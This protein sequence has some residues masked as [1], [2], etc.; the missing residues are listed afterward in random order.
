MFSG[1]N[2]KLA[3]SKLIIP[4]EKHPDGKT[5]ID[6]YH[7]RKAQYNSEEGKVQ[8]FLAEFFPS[9]KPKEAK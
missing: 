2:L 7:I 9:L 3:P 1:T 4:I 8:A 5:T 6:A